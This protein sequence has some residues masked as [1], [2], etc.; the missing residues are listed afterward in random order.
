ML[1]LL[2]GISTVVQVGFLHNEEAMDFNLEKIN[3]ISGF[4]K[5][6]QHS[7]GGRGLEVALEIGSS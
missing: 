7:I 3:P 5:N 6:F 4:Q 1:M 2:S